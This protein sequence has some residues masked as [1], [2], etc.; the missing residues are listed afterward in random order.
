MPATPEYIER[1]ICHFPFQLA[2]SLS[3][4]GRLFV[5]I[6]VLLFDPFNGR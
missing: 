3:L 5:L 6:V 1:N 4:L 2:A